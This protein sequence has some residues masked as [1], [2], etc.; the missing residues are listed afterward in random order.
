MANDVVKIKIG[1]SVELLIEGLS[2]SVLT[3]EIQARAALSLVK[4]GISTTRVISAGILGGIRTAA[5]NVGN[6]IYPIKYSINVLKPI[7]ALE[8]F[9]EAVNWIENQKATNGLDLDLANDA[10]DYLRSE[11]KHEFGR[12]L[13][14]DSTTDAPSPKKEK[15]NKSS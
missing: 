14:G 1:D 12:G 4:H 10:I 8:I 15:D 11:F 7:T 5:L 3:P 13:N 6:E 2:T 9:S